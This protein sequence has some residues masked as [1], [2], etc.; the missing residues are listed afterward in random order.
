MVSSPTVQQE[1]FSDLIESIYS[2][3]V[4]V[5]GFIAAA[6]SCTLSST[7]FDSVVMYLNP[8]DGATKTVIGT[9]ADSINNEPLAGATVSISLFVFGSGQVLFAATTAE[10]GSYTIT[11]IP[12]EN[13]TALITAQMTNYQT[14]A[15]SA[16]IGIADTA[17]TTRIDMKLLS[18]ASV[19]SPHSKSIQQKRRQVVAVTSGGIINLTN[20]PGSGVLRLHDLKGTLLFTR[21]FNGTGTGNITIPLP[22]FSGAVRVFRLSQTTGNDLTG[23]VVTVKQQ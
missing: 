8:A 5:E 12:S 1:T 4:S 3:S 20:V 14:L 15:E 18:N 7:S 21:S 19:T 13:P 2:V 10:N 17:D 22:P 11:G 16:T 23:G 6:R 9:I